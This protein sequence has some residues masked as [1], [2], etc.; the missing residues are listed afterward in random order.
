MSGVIWNDLPGMVGDLSVPFPYTEAWNEKPIDACQPVNEQYRQQ[1]VYW[2]SRHVTGAIPICEHGCN[3]RECLI[4]SG[5]ERG[6]IWFDDRADWKG[7]YPN[8]STGRPRL[9]FFEWY[10]LWLDDRLT[11]ALGTTCSSS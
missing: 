6:N 3:L 7:L 1:D 11:K 4:I 10:R 5:Q 2:S 9:K 8:E